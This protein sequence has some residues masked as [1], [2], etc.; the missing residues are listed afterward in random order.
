MLEIDW[1]FIVYIKIHRRVRHF[2]AQR[3]PSTLNT[4]IP[5]MENGSQV[6]TTLGC[7]KPSRRYSRMIS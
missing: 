5:T 1:T 6:R 2:L 7:A 4:R 3:V